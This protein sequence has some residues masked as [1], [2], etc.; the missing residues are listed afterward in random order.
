MDSKAMRGAPDRVA[1]GTRGTWE[2]VATAPTFSY[3]LVECF[4]ESKKQPTLKILQR[5]PV[6]HAWF[7]VRGTT[8]RRVSLRVEGY[9]PS[10]ARGCVVKD[11]GGKLD[12]C[13]FVC[14]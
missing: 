9:D 7:K 3:F 10:T 12:C 11:C 14:V 4:S 13:M 5:L 2:R 8:V 1:G 6:A